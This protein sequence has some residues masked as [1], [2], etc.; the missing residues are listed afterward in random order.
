MR[1]EI[2]GLLADI[3]IRIPRSRIV[4]VVDQYYL[5]DENNHRTPINNSDIEML[6]SDGYLEKNAIGGVSPTSKAIDDSDNFYAKKNIPGLHG[7]QIEVAEF[8]YKYS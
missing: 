7:K 1:D 2:K 5:V 6:I 4:L 8:P 3:T